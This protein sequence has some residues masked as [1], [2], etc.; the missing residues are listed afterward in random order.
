MASNNASR[1]AQSNLSRKKLIQDSSR[2][3]CQKCLQIGHYTYQCTN[4]RSYASRVTRTKLLDDKVKENIVEKSKLSDIT[5]EPP[6]KKSR[7]IETK[8]LQLPMA[9]DLSDLS[10]QTSSESD[11]ESSDT[12][13]TTSNNTSTS[14]ADSVKAT[15]AG[16]RSK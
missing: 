15:S 11:S 10:S 12:S 8:H 3:K 2:Y 1:L 14:T 9:D 16:S 4:K 7:V 5:T 6:T 13:S